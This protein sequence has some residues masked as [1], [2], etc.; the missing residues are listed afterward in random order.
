MQDDLAKILREEKEEVKQRSL[1]RRKEFGK[2]I[3]EL[4]RPKISLKKQEEMKKIIEMNKESVRKKIARIKYERPANS[5]LNKPSFR[6]KERS[7]DQQEFNQTKFHESDQ[8]SSIVEEDEYSKSLAFQSKKNEGDELSPVRAYISNNEL[9]PVQEKWIKRR[10][11]KQKPRSKSSLNGEY[12]RQNSRS[13]AAINSSQDNTNRNFELP[14]DYLLEQRKKKAESQRSDLYIEKIPKKLTGDKISSFENI[15]N[16]MSKVERTA[17]RLEKKTLDMNNSTNLLEDNLKVGS[18][19]V[20]A[21]KAK[22][23]LL[24]QL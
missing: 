18:M 13:Y 15:R 14:V 5:I 10:R 1:K 21:I 7:Y 23:A 16:E 11:K 17:S 8:N 3:D 6:L 22:V 9:E 24:E 20:D 2:L 4:Y 12:R 19:Y